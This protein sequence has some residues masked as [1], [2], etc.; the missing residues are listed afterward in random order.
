MQN[1]LDE[2]QSLIKFLRIKPYDDLGEW[3]D[4]IDR[5]MKN[6]RGDVAIKRLRHYLKIFMKRRTKDILKKEGALN[7]GGKPSIAGEENHRI[8]SH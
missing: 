2:L 8:Q 1:N 4:Q 3:K 7:P 5:P 6:G